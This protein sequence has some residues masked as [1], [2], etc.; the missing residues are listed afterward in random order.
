[1]P[2]VRLCSHHGVSH[3]VTAVLVLRMQR[4]LTPNASV[5]WSL[6]HALCLAIAPF[7][8]SPSGHDIMG[9]CPAI[10]LQ[11]RRG[12]PQGVSALMM[13]DHERTTS[14][15][16][17]VMSDVPRRLPSC[18]PVHSK[19]NLAVASAYLQGAGGPVLLVLFLLDASSCSTCSSSTLLCVYALAHVSC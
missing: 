12:T 5:R 3:E 15:P 19:W 7:P 10:A 4:F 2:S 1:M 9:H 18:T 17:L 13:H 6:R 11:P 8:L 16:A 14:L